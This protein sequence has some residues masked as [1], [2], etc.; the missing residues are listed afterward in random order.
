MPR[1]PRNR[2][3]CDHFIWNVFRRGAI[4]YADGRA[5]NPPL[6]KHSLGARD[7]NE[8]LDALRELDRH[9]AVELGLIE[10]GVSCEESLAIE[11]GWARYFTYA[12][13]PGVL[14]GVSA[15]TLNRYRAARDKHLKFCQA[16]RIATW[17]QV[18]R[19]SVERYAAWL[20]EAGYADASIYTECTLIKQ[21][22]KWMIE[23]EQLLPE[24]SRIRLRLQRSHES[25][26]YC[27]SR[28]EVAAMIG[29]C[30]KTP[31]LHYLADLIQTLAMTGLR[32]G[33]AVDLRSSDVDLHTGVITLPD[34]RHSGRPRRKGKQLRTTKGR[35][36][37]RI[38]IHPRLHPVLQAM[39]R[40]RD[41]RVFH[42]PRGGQLKPDTVRNALVDRVIGALSDRFPTAEGEI[43]FADGRLHSLRH[44][45]VSQA[46]LSGASEGEIREW[47]GHADSRIVERYRH[48]RMADAQRKMEQLNLVDDADATPPPTHRKTQPHG[49]SAKEDAVTD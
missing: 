29:L 37:R 22:V 12:Q 46:F 17:Q 39:D 35:R 6:G 45:F 49:N 20:H 1:K 11:T 34:N 15:A 42:G 14:G 25:D 8:A 5:N 19:K 4:Y 9:M 23:E 30:R 21:V 36:T 44:Y 43:G 13:R 31:D 16:R 32:I 24:S 40:H 38:P 27:Y 41:G 7:L 26:T 2:I 3:S 10:V 48:L 28:Q 33:E 18:D 47:V